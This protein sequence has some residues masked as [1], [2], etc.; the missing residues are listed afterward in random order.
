MIFLLLRFLVNKTDFNFMQFRV[1]LFAPVIFRLFNYD[2]DEDGNDI[3][4]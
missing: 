4:L 2:D 3:F 1:L